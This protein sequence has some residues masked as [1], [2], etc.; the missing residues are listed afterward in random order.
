[1]ALADKYGS[2]VVVEVLL[3]LESIPRA[4]C[5]GGRVVVV[6]GYEQQSCH[7]WEVNDTDAMGLGDH[8]G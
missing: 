5:C 1:V 7:R 4:C 8:W 3:G 2:H 6:D